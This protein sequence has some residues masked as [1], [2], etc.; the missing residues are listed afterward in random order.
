MN[1]LQID[2]VI[3]PLLLEF[4]GHFTKMSYKVFTSANNQYSRRQTVHGLPTFVLAEKAAHCA[5]FSCASARDSVLA[6]RV[7]AFRPI[8]GNQNR[9]EFCKIVTTFNQNHHREPS[10]KTAPLASIHWQARPESVPTRKQGGKV[11]RT[12]S[13]NPLI[14]VLT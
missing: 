10:Q 11:W 9:T 5:G 13:K 8:R 12:P 4:V 6:L 14:I 1:L 7:E 2:I 3:N